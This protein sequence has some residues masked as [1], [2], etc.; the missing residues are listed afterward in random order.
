MNRLTE[1]LENTNIAYMAIA[2]TLSKKD[3]E[4]EGSKPILEGI[5]AIFQRL[6][7]YEDTGLEPEEILTSDEMKEI[8]IKLGKLIDYMDLEEQGR[9]IKLPQ[10]ERDLIQ[11]EYEAAE[12]MLNDIYQGEIIGETAYNVINLA[13][14]NI[15][16]MISGRKGA[17]DEN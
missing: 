4:I 7:A 16:Y 14:Q 2:K 5:Y 15:R 9:L 11:D 6:A 13:L 8:N 1:R 3:Q 10:N 12:A 17:E